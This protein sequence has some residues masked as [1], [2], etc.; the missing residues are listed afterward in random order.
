MLKNCMNGLRVEKGLVTFRHYLNTLS[1]RRF[2]SALLKKRKRIL[3]PLVF[4]HV[5]CLAFKRSTPIGY[6]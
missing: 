5:L 2:V 1:H 4:P 3:Q 6:S